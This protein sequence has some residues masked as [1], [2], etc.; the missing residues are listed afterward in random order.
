MKTYIKPMTRM[1]QTCTGE[2]IEIKVTDKK[3]ITIEQY[4]V[5]N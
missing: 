3:V 2:H 4:F 1:A 5:K